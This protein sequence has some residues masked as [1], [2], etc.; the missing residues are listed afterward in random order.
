MAAVSQTLIEFGRDFRWGPTPGVEQ[1][2]TPRY[3]ITLVPDFPVPGPNNASWIRCPA[4][5][6]DDMVREVHAIVAPRNLALMWVLDPG[7]Q[8]VDLA[9]RLS[10]HGILADPHGEESVVMVLP[11]ETQ[12]DA[13][14]INGLAIQDAL[15]DLAAFK[16]SDDVGAEAFIGVPFGENT[17]PPGALERRLAD[18]RLAGNR[19]VLLATIDGEPAGSA[20]ITL[21]PPRGAMINGG[22]VRPRFRGRGVYRALVAA[23]LEIARREGVAGLA[24]WAGAMSAPT[25]ARLGFQPVSWRRFYLDMS[26]AVP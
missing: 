25:L 5:E 8:P 22:S 3:Q 15:A 26:T 11:S 20:S 17:V 23:R 19:R 2:T 21:Y 16:A 13:P 10:L 1:I 7:T 9:D 18:I 4:E 12:V 14:A 6:V 24:V